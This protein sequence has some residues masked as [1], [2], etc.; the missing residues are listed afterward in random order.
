MLNA[1]VEQRKQWTDEELADVN[2]RL[3]GASPE[4]ILAWA[5]ERFPGKV[6][7]AV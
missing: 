5:I 4:E 6:T 7:L 2:R 1:T 3:E